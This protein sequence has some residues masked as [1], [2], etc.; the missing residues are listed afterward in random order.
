[1]MEVEELRHMKMKEVMGAI[2]QVVQLQLTIQSSMPIN[3][4]MEEMMPL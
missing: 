4:L 2:L 3:Q 1:M